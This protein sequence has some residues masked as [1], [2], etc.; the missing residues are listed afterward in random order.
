MNDGRG[1]VLV[2]CVRTIVC[3]GGLRLEKGVLEEGEFYCCGSRQAGPGRYLKVALA[4][5]TF[6]TCGSSI[7][8]L[9][10]PKHVSHKVYTEEVPAHGPTIRIPTRPKPSEL[11]A[12]RMIGVQ[13]GT[14]L[15][16]HKG[17]GLVLKSPGARPDIMNVEAF[18]VRSYGPV[19]RRQKDGNCF[20]AATYNGF[21]IAFGREDANAFWVFQNNIGLA[22]DSVRHLQDLF[23]HARLR[24]DAQKISK[25]DNAAFLSDLFAYFNNLSD[26][27]YLAF[28]RGPSDHAVVIDCSRRLIWDSVVRYP[29]RYSPDT[30]RLCAGAQ[31]T[32]RVNVEARKLSPH[33]A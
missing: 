21:H 12:Q 6:H 11:E 1:R 32:G 5:I 17:F 28:L 9:W 24:V 13:L 26:G 15:E 27:F 3:G 18:F 20:A 7:G 8:D 14:W 29:L 23:D 4:D 30:F 22:V 19:P 25:R 10:K 16:N 2:F 31:P 33:S